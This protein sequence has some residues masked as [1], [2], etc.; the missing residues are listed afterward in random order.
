MRPGMR[1]S[2]APG[3]TKDMVLSTEGFI[4]T[5]GAFT[6]I[7]FNLKPTYGDRYWITYIDGV[8][9]THD[10]VPEDLLEGRHIAPISEIFTDT[11]IVVED[12][13]DWANEDYDPNFQAIEF[14]E[15]SAEQIS[16]R[17]DATP[18]F[19]VSEPAGT[20]QL[21]AFSLGGVKRFTN[22]AK[23]NRNPT[24]GVYEIE[25]L[26]VGG[27]RTVNLY[28][29][30]VKVA[31]GFRTGD[32]TITITELLRSGINGSVAVVYTTDIV[33]GDAELKVRFPASYQIHFTTS[34]LSFPRT[35]EAI[36]EDDGQG[37][38][39]TF[40]TEAALS[41][42]TYNVA[43]VAVSDTGV[44]EIVPLAATSEI[45]TSKPDFPLS[46]NYKDGAS[47]ATRVR[48]T[49]PDATSTYRFFVSP[50]V[51]TPVDL[52]TVFQTESA[53]A[54]EHIVTLGTF[55]AGI[56]GD[57]RILIRTVSSGGVEEKAGAEIK[58]TYLAGV[59]V[60]PGPNSPGIETFTT[61][62]REV[63]VT[64]SYNRQEEPNLAA[65]I[66]LFVVAETASFV[67]GTPQ[68]TVTIP[69]ATS[70]RSSVNV[71]FTTAGDGF[72][73]VAIRAK[74]VGGVQDAN[75]DFITVF[76]STAVPANI[77]NFDT[78]VSR[79]GVGDIE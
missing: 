51:G 49:A 35:P 29:N 41:A 2:S 12:A 54:G 1:T 17:W 62:G 20:G 73:K 27:V 42:G 38:R 45:I 48:F 71:S 57:I 43:I 65:E 72:F 4:S 52:D 69:A 13:G 75:V 14:E 8:K 76:L 53:G 77:A 11:C 24:Q 67:Y 23:D 26:N 37:N 58:V 44:A 39:F 15:E 6:L 18:Q 64:A 28:A 50:S 68:T 56:T 46:F 66:D 70:G 34:A 31:T 74:T 5:A 59:R 3:D 61:N 19:V 25:L 32:G 21:T 36:V 16:M 30:N 47:T 7:V 78:R 9:A 10:H 40:T 79:G 22:V 60:I 33:K 63:T 55:G